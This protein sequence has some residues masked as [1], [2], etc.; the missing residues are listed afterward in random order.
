MT[1]T[2]LDREKR[3]IEV[4]RREAPDL[5]GFLEGM[6]IAFKEPAADPVTGDVLIPLADNMEAAE[7]DRAEALIEEFNRMR[8]TRAN[9]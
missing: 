3:V 2:K 4:D 9:F 5:V 6:E 1:P 7:F 8:T